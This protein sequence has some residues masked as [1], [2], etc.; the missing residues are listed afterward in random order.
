MIGTSST[1]LDFLL[2]EDFLPDL[3]DFWGASDLGSMVY[4]LDLR[5]EG[6]ETTS[7]LSGVNG[8]FLDGSDS[9]PRF[10]FLLKAA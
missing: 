6:L 4:L 10:F 8:L 5:V 9:L 2:L 7:A 1:C 3:V